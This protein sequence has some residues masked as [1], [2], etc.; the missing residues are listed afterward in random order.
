[1]TEKIIRIGCASGFWGDSAIAAPQ[2]VRHGELHY[3]VADYLAE[4]TMSIMA[5]ARAKDPALGYATDFVS[6]VLKRLLPELAARHIKVVTNA[7]GVN[8]EACA[9]A[10]RGLI[11]ASGLSLKVATVGGDDLMH[12]LSELRAS[13]IREMQSGAPLPETLMSANAYLG[14]APIAEALRQGADI[15]ITGRVVDSALA[16]GPLMYEFG[17]RADDYRRLAAGSLAG[18]IIECGAQCTGG[19]FTDWHDVPDW[20]N[21]GYPVIECHEDGSFVVTKSPQTGGLVSRGTV[22]EQLLYEIGDP[23]AYILPD[24]VCD[25]S[26]VAIDEVG[27][28]RVRVSGAR[29]R[30]PTSSFKVS[31]T[32]FD[33]YRAVAQLTI[34]GSDAVLKAQ[35]TADAILARTQHIFRA[36]NLGDYRDVDVEILGNEAMYG[37]AARA[38]HPRE[39]V[40]RIAVAHEEKSA[41]EIFVRE[42][43]PA[44]TSMAPGTT[45]GGGG[46]AKPQPIVRLFSFLIP[47]AMISPRIICDGHEMRFEPSHDHGGE[48]QADDGEVANSPA[49]ISVAGTAKEATQSVPLIRLA[50][51]RSGDK[52]NDA[53]IGIIARD[54][55]FLPIIRAEVTAERVRDYFRHVVKG[56]VMRYDLPG[57]GAVNFLL[58]DAL[59]GGGIASLRNDPQGKAYAQMLL[60]MPVDVP[61]SLLSR[62]FP[63]L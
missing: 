60:D 34:G 41:L 22:A 16:L 33:G 54:R 13:D 17:W 4:I 47:K 2:L 31:A 21:I 38:L 57:V 49:M 42:I 12:R 9:A 20:D 29:G 5:R 3:L 58:K 46:R 63:G 19:L 44:G 18:H 30:A 55:V 48:D 35:K 24:V 23:R 15:I 27:K 8:P 56:D 36:L 53:N 7:G 39:V 61:R 40:L 43:A 37:N 50:W 25:F 11:T 32:Y 62:I 59:G 6:I 26:N 1:M 10:I 28:D 45:G 14:A 52:G 51:G